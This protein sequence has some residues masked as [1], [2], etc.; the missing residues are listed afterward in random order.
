[1]TFRVKLLAVFIVT[2]IIS[3][4]IVAWTVSA[5]TRRAFEELDR[6]RTVALVQQF[7]REFAHRADDVARRVTG[8]AD[9]EASVRMALELS[10]P[11]PDYS[12]Y[13]NDARGLARSYQLDFVEMVGPDGTIF[14]SSHW[15]TR[16][17]A[18]SEWLAGEA[19]WNAQG[20]FLRREEF[21]MEGDTTGAGRPALVLVA[22]RTTVGVG[23]K[24]VHI[25]G[26]QRLEKEFLASLVLPVGMRAF[27]YRNLEPTF[28]GLALTT[29]TGP[30]DRPDKLAPLVESVRHSGSEATETVQ[31]SADP[32]AAETVHAIPLSGRA[33]ELL[34]V[35][36]VGSSRRELVEMQSFIRSMALLAGAVGILLGVLLSWWASARVTRPVERLATAAGHVAAGD[37]TARVDSGSRDEIGKLA[38]AFNQMTRQLVE[39][40][41]RLLQAERVAAWRELARRLAH[42]LK[43][44]LYPLQITVENLQRARQNSPGQFEEVFRESTG[45]LLAELENL[46]TIVGRF[47]DFAKMP[48]PQLQGVNLNDIARNAVRLHEAQFAAPGR[49]QIVP[50]LY[51]QEDLPTIQA[52][53]ELLHR[54]LQNLVL[55]A[56]DAMPAGGTLTLRTRRQDA[57]VLLEVSDTGTGLTR[58]ECE[59]LFTPYYTTKHHGTGL[60]LAIVQSV[61]SDHGGKISVD[62]E[63]GRGTTFRIEL[64]ARPLSEKA[65]RR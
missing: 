27:L 63:P 3:I 7:R 2:V 11:A 25:I 10:R 54:A 48:P 12:L 47:S 33:S 13:V 40:R 64:P 45:T 59:R 23:E 31:W 21:P 19:D 8:I 58:E 38:A 28:S 32:A 29:P 16:F 44:P 57:G 61:V 36:L 6:Q 51:L 42:E 41:E 20:A 9:A 1:M 60:G 34:G 18:R 49:P 55:N 15:P 14:S 65:E 37:W 30:F 53:P 4:G 24:K 22:V 35:L 46:K 5:S 50:E 62:S 43:N 52:D 17:G 56:L 26:G 39:Q